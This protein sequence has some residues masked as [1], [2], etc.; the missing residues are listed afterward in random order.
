MST[1]RYGAIL[2]ADV[3]VFRR[4][5]TVLGVA[6]IKEARLKVMLAWAKR[7]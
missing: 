1:P 5:V 4:T 7:V 6:R 3:V 2:A